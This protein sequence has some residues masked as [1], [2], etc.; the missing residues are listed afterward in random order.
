MT[1]IFNQ[2]IYSYNVEQACSDDLHN[3]VT[4]VIHQFDTD[5][6][7]AMDYIGKFHDRL[8]GAF[9]LTKDRLPSWGELRFQQNLDMWN[10]SS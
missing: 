4:I 6:S 7:G 3:T 8:A 2:D 5:I 1:Y 10:W 9:L